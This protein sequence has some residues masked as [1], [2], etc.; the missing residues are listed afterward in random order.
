VTPPSKLSVSS[1][2]YSHRCHKLK[3]LFYGLSGIARLEPEILI[4]PASR[5]NYLNNPNFFSFLSSLSRWDLVVF[6]FFF[7]PYSDSSLPDVGR[8]CPPPNILYFGVLF[9]SS[10]FFFSLVSCSAK[11]DFFFFFFEASVRKSLFKCYGIH[12]LLRCQRSFFRY[13]PFFSCSFFF[14]Y[15]W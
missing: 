4:V 9:R 11:R 8:W 1:H 13:Y 12:I 7:R 15:P 14:F 6:S 2:F 10:S 5:Q 3:H